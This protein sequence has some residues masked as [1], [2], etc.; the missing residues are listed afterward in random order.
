VTMGYINPH[1]PLPFNITAR[2]QDEGK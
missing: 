1:L 2:S